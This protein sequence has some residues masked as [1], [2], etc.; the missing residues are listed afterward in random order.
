M[1]GLDIQTDHI[2]EIA[3]V[4]TDKTL[5]IISEELHIVIH[6]SDTILNNMSEWCKRHHQMV[7]L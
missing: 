1:T 2:L 5:K 3:C 4:V 6:Q 7:R